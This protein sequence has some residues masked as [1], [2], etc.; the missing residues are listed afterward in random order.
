MLKS[1]I[2][3]KSKELRSANITLRQCIEDTDNCEEMIK[4]L[5]LS[6]PIRGGQGYVIKYLIIL[7]VLDNSLALL[8]NGLRIIIITSLSLI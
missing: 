6:N 3:D 8:N 1:I 7:K 2:V 5:L 4:F